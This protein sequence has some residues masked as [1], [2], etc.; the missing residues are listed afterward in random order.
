[1]MVSTKDVRDQ[2]AG[3]GLVRDGG[4]LAIRKAWVH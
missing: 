4:K 2:R 1:M 3:D